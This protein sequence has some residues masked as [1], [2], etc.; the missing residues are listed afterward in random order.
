MGGPGAQGRAATSLGSGFWVSATHTPTSPSGVLHCGLAA[1]VS[2]SGCQSGCLAVCKSA[3][4]SLIT[5][6]GL[7]LI[8]SLAGS[9]ADRGALPLLRRQAFSWHPRFST[10]SMCHLTPQGLKLTV[11]WSREEFL[12]SLTALFPHEQRGI[13]AFYG[14]LWGIFEW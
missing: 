5:P 8:S 11:G 12:A 6:P 14:E 7:T 13:H 4:R 10:P 1:R 9:L 2:L 3:H